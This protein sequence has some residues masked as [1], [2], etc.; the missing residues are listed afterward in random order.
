LPLVYDGVNKAPK[1]HNLKSEKV[2]E[3]GE[4]DRKILYISR[5]DPKFARP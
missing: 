4:K 5:A 3:E 1:A 2:C